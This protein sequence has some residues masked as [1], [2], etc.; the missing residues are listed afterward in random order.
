MKHKHI[1]Y[2]LTTGEVIT[3]STSKTLN[4]CVNATIQSDRKFF[5]NSNSKSHWVF[6]HDGNLK[7]HI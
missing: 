7:K 6:S 3:A 2:N 4:K 5:Y 1:A